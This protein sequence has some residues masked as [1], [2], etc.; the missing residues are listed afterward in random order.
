MRFFT[1]DLGLVEFL[2]THGHRWK[3]WRSIPVETFGFARSA[4]LQ[5]DI[6]SYVAMNTAALQSNLSDGRTQRAFGRDTEAV[7]KT[8]QELF[9]ALTSA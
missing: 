3:C 1:T 4:A 7:I 5:R 6:E 8:P 9:A 2:V